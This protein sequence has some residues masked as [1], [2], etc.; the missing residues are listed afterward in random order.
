MDNTPNPVPSRCPA[1]GAPLDLS[2]LDITQGQ[3]ICPYCGTPITLPGGSTTSSRTPDRLSPQRTQTAIRVTSDGRL[4]KG[5][6]GG[7][8]LIGLL[9]LVVIV[10]LLVWVSGYF[11]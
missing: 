2:R 9:I 10:G 1:C 8:L 11:G 3:V 7:K 6:W 5:G 4:V